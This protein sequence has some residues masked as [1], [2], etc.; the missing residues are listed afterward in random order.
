[1]SKETNKKKSKKGGWTW[2]SPA[3]RQAGVPSALFFP[4][5]LLA[6]SP[7]FAHAAVQITEV[8]YDPP[9]ANSGAQWVELANEGDIAVSLNGYKLAEGGTNH[10][11]TVALGTSTLLAGEVVIVASDP[12][13]FSTLFPHYQ[14]S[15]FKSALS[16]TSKKGETLTLLTA[17]AQPVDSI[18]YDP[19][20]GAAGDGNTL[21]RSGAVLVVGA[22]NP[23]SSATTEPLVPKV[24][25]SAATAPTTKVVKPVAAHTANVPTAVKLVPK[26]SNAAAP[27]LTTINLPKGAT[28]WALGGFGALLLGVSALWYLW[29]H[30]RARRG[31]VLAAEEF[32]I[33]E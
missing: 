22:P 6:L 26:Q 3:C 14:G 28:A 24:V 1:M 29:L 30:S 15:L 17:Q 20:A 4:V 9:G 25:V 32:T 33:E 2:P 23:G 12:Q 10:K 31:N 5:F 16:L 8:M 18:T 19:S 27:L 21:H 13:T 11:I 7:H